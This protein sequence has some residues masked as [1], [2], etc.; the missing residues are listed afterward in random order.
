MEFVRKVV[1]TFNIS[2]Y[3]DIPWNHIRS[4]ILQC[5]VDSY[6]IWEAKLELYPGIKR[7]S[8]VVRQAATLWLSKNTK[9]SETLNGRTNCNDQKAKEI[10]FIEV[11]S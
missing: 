10:T 4:Y 9:T 7:I 5:S 3:I 2:F 11:G 6:D 8:I 1:I